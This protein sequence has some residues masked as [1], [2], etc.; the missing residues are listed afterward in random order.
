MKREKDITITISNIFKKLV[1]ILVRFL[2]LVGIILTF[3]SDTSGNFNNREIY[4]SRND[5]RIV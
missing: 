4:I 2:I 1:C 3:V 5:N